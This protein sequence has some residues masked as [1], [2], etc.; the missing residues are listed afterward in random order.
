MIEIRNKGWIT[1]PLA[2]KCNGHGET[3]L[4]LNLTLTL[5]TRHERW[6]RMTHINDDDVKNNAT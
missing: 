5:D 6:R 2:T 3:H 1:P 4:P